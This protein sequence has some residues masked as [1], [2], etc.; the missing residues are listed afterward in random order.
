MI[1]LSSLPSGVTLCNVFGDEPAIG[2][3]VLMTMLP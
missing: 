2:E 3:Y 1:D